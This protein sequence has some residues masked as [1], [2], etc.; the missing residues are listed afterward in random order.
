MLLQTNKLPLSLIHDESGKTPHVAKSTIE[1]A[2]FDTVFGPK[3][4]RKRAKLSAQSLSDLADTADGD[5]DSYIERCEQKA[6][7]GESVDTETSAVEPIFKKGQSKR[8]WNELYRVLDASV[9][10]IAAEPVT[11]RTNRVTGCHSACA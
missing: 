4:N 1:A 7:L 6:L 9:C 3:A 2:P 5:L 10:T 8:I 11:I